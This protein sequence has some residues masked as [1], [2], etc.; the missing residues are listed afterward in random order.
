MLVFSTRSG[1]AN[2]ANCAGGYKLDRR[3]CL[4]GKPVYVSEEKERFLGKTAGGA[5]I[6]GKLADLDSFISENVSSFGG[7]H[8]SA[9]IEPEDGPWENYE[10]TRVEELEFVVKQGQ[11]DYASCAGTY[12]ERA[13]VRLN[14]MPV[15]LNRERG[16]MLAADT[17]GGWTIASMDFLEDFLRTQ[18]ATFGGF[19]GSSELEN[20]WQ[21]YDVQRL[22]P[23]REDPL[24]RW[25]K[26]E[27]RNV[28]FRAVANSGICRTEAN[29]R[30]HSLSLDACTGVSVFSVGLRTRLGT[31]AKSGVAVM[32]L[33]G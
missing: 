25:E 19:H 15:Y 20:G 18:P 23:K 3:Q 9:A 33:I 11:P 2:Y 21:N 7:F 8:S 32:S 6:I 10:V 17:N 30:S 29:L 4:N 28:T 16:R 1:K 5:W 14:G 22:L 13:D 12:Q 27:N 24:A 26:L 31:K